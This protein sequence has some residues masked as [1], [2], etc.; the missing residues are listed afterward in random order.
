MKPKEVYALI[1]RYILLIALAIPNLFLFYA[2]FTPLTLYPTFAILNLFYGAN[3]L[4][5]NII[6]L[7]GVYIQL[8]PA[9]IAGAAYYLLLILN[10]TTPMPLPKR[11]RSLLFL[12]TAFLVLNIIRIVVFSFLAVQGFQYFDISHNL[13]WYF[14]STILVIILWFSNVLIFK[15]K[16]IPIYTD[17]TNLLSDIIKKPT[18]RS[19]GKK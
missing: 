9:C 7:N 16:N 17:V 13:T 8:I 5:G 12:F 14:G 18:K 15:I 10:L 2:I 19:K 1:T 4:A 3:L 6:F 11:I